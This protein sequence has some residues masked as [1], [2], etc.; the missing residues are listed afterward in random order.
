MSL[1]IIRPI[2]KQPSMA[3]LRSQRVWIGT[4]YDRRSPSLVK[5]LISRAVRRSQTPCLRV[6]VSHQ[7]REVIMKGAKTHQPHRPSLLAPI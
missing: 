7:K 2:A 6:V 5:L 4:K 1:V 3:S